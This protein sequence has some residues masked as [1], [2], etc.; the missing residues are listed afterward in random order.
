VAITFSSVPEYGPSKTA[1]DIF[2]GDLLM[3]GD[4][5]QDFAESS[6]LQRRVR[7]DDLPRA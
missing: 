7:R 5:A 3:R 2:A 4:L 1:Q 6:D